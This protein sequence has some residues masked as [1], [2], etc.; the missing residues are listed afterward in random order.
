MNSTRQRRQRRNRGATAWVLL[1][2]IL[3]PVGVVAA[4]LWF[5]WVRTPISEGQAH[6]H[7]VMLRTSGLSRPIVN[8]LDLRFGDADGDLV[9]DVPADSKALIDP[10]T[11]VFTYI[12]IP[13]DDD[14]PTATD[15]YKQAFADF[16][17]HLQVIT[18]KP[19]EYRVY[20]SVN[21]QLKAMRDG[22][23]HV[24]GFNTGAVP[25]AVNLA[26]FVPVCKLASAD[27]V[28]SYRMLI[29]VPAD[30]PIR[31]VGD[32]KQHELVVT[33][34]ESNSGYKAPLVLLRS[35]GLVLERDYTLRFSGGHDQSIKGIASKTYQAAAVA[36][37]V[38]RRAVG[39]GDIT[40]NQY[41]TV[42]ESEAFPTACF[43]Y[44]HNLKPELAA[45]V[46]LAFSSFTWTSSTLEKEFATSDQSRFVPANFK[47][48]WA[49]VRRI[50]NET[51][52]EYHIN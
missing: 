45:K 14:N 35:N 1:L 27:G 6:T 52:T 40:T 22:E 30:S 34:P 36:G 19:A 17:A 50:D 31:S 2:A 20:E 3:I 47:D 44:A 16:V 24:S 9:A 13:R 10:P 29:I 4:L 32:L 23:L 41:R 15:P 26:G 11:L 33:D 37:D 7:E 38:L 51:G 28:A 42:Y 46:R 12:P 21:D 18:G 5:L 48:D 8:K 49:L 43:G 39:K 25:M